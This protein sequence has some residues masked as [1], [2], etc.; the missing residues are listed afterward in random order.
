MLASYIVHRNSKKRVGDGTGF[1]GRLTKGNNLATVLMT[2]Y[3]VLSEKESTSENDSTSENLRNCKIKF[4]GS[5]GQLITIDLEN[6]LLGT[7]VLYSSEV[8]SSTYTPVY[9]I[10]QLQ[11]HTYRFIDNKMLL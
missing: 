9:T 8:T 4:T 10:S 3:H 2:N 11:F 6:I 7:E 5:D 1:I